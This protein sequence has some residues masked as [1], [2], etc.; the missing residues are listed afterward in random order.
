MTSEQVPKAAPVKMRV[1][2]KSIIVA[3]ILMV[4]SLYC[5]ALENNNLEVC[6]LLKRANN[7]TGYLLDKDGK[8][9]K[10]PMDVGRLAVSGQHLVD[11]VIA[12]TQ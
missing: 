6:N 12:P 2:L 11:K 10:G 1:I 8:L 4:S 9:S 5:H 3:S 7:P